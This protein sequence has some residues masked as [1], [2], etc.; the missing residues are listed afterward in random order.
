MI[1]WCRMT[2][3]VGSGTVWYAEHYY[4][5]MV[6]NGVTEDLRY[7]MNAKE[8]KALAKSDPTDPYPYKAGKD[9]ARFLSEDK[10]KSE[11]ISQYKAMFPGANLLVYGDSSVIEPQ[12]ILDGPKGAAEWSTELVSL[13]E[14]IDW[15]EEDETLMDC[16]SGEWGLVMV[17]FDTDPKSYYVS[18]KKATKKGPKRKKWGIEMLL[19]LP[20][21]N[22][23][24]WHEWKWYETEDER[25]DVIEHISDARGEKFRR[26]NR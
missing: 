12:P 20:F 2:T 26:V 4:A 9:T 18:R 24:G 19:D 14:E 21:A 11:A 6:C 23:S 15:W 7:V 8:A 13:C 5:R 10:L 22:L 1:V 17:Q 3:W 25:D 16:L